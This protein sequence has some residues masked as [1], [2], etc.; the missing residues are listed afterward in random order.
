MDMKR[1]KKTRYQNI[2]KLCNNKRI[3]FDAKRYASR[4]FQEFVK[5]RSDRIQIGLSMV[6]WSVKGFD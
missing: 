3:I 2:Y 1:Y 6:C 4:Q 5:N